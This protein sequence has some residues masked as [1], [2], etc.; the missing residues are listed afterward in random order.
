MPVLFNQNC[1]AVLSLPNE[2]QHE[3]I[4]C[5]QVF[6]DYIQ[7]HV[8][9]WFTWAWK[10]QLGVRCVE[11]LILVSGCTLVTLWAA[12]EF[13]DDNM[14]A[15]ISLASRTLNNGGASFVWSNIWGRVLYPNSHSGSVRSS[16][17]VQSTHIDTSSWFHEEQNSTMTQD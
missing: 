10:N 6:E 2:G 4:I 8:E 16:G 14:D 5:T 11:N 7:A 1:G 13:V 3:D 12:A 15:E 9:S 17:Y